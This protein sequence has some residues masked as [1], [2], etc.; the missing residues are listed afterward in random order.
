M[1]QLAAVSYQSQV[2]SAHAT[3]QDVL[4]QENT[5]KVNRLVWL[6]SVGVFGVFSETK[7]RSCSS[8]S[9]QLAKLARQCLPAQK[10]NFTLLWRHSSDK[11]FIR[12]CFEQL[13]FYCME[14]FAIN[15]LFLKFT[16]ARVLFPQISGVLPV[17]TAR[18]NDVDRT[19]TTV[20][21]SACFVFV[22][23]VILYQNIQLGEICRNKNIELLVNNI[24]SAPLWSVPKGEVFSIQ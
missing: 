2:K 19:A 21:T 7:L 4:L 18:S 1:L 5:A 13:N 16:F 14:T 24:K 6:V 8:I 20:Y 9:C 22:V 11:T 10:T 17:L 15:T 3:L 23:T 12:I